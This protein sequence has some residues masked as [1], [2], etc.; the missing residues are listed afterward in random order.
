MSKEAILV[1]QPID[2]VTHPMQLSNGSGKVLNT[3]MTMPTCPQTP[4]PKLVTEE[5]NVA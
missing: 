4:K 5:K 3:I 1:G 2:D